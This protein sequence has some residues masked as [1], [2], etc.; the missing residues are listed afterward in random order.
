M[1]AQRLR[2]GDLSARTGI[3]GSDEMSQF[4]KTFDEMADSFQR[5]QES[6][7]RQ[8]DNLRMLGQELMR[9]QETE[10]GHIARELHDDI[11]QNLTAVSINLQMVKGS[12]PDLGSA[13]D[14][15]IRMLERILKAMRD[16]SLNLRPPMIDE[17]GLAAALRWYL[18]SQSGPGVQRVEFQTSV[19]ETRFTPERKLGIFRIVQEAMTN[20]IRHAGARLVTVSLNQIDDHCEL[21]VQDDG[22]GFDVA[23]HQQN[24]H[25][26]LSLGL[27]GMQERASLMGGIFG[28]ESRVGAGTLV[29][30]RIPL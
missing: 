1:A 12:H 10:R 9:V 24:P 11:G 29:R 15:C 5:A 18:A 28:I 6:N 23:G 4:A 22:C 16:L 3:T 19:D 26:R 30:V 17:V 13:M 7:A 20:I 27:I 2:E 25:R 14:N 8:E 21:S